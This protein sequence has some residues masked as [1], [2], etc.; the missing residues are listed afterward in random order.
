MHALELKLPGDEVDGNG[1]DV[2]APLRSEEWEGLEGEEVW[3]EALGK[4]ER[5]GR[6]FVDER[7]GS[8]GRRYKERKGGEGE[9]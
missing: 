4:D 7:G 1:V 3:I 8:F 5:L 6:E 9:T 2:V